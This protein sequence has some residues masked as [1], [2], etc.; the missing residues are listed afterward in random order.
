M[1]KDL[2]AAMI[3]VEAVLQYSSRLALA[4]RQQA[5]SNLFVA[6]EEARLL[7]LM[8]GAMKG[9]QVQISSEF[10]GSAQASAAGRSRRRSSAC[11]TAL[12]EVSMSTALDCHVLPAWPIPLSA[13]NH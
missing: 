10:S 8:Q 6:L 5:V 7:V 9:L 2:I 11:Q 3:H 1:P 12:S 13:W 4:R